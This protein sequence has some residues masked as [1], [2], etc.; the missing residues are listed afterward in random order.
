M[1]N[2]MFV[3]VWIA[4]C[5]A[6]AP[7][8]TAPTP[9]PVELPKIERVAAPAEGILANA[10]LIETG[11]GVVV[12]DGLLRVT[13]ARVLRGRVEATGKPLRG[14]ILTHGHP[15]HYNGVAML[16]G[17]SGVPIVATA[18]VDRVIREHDA[19]KERQWRPM[20]GDEWPA[21]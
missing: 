2:L 14:V 4:G 7:A 15:D 13:D 17:D 19:E 9:A 20:F 11:E 12:V 3:S 18:A 16:A 1:R 10:Y 8:E 5:S 6:A 21:R